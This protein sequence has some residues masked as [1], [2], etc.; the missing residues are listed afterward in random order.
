MRTNQEVR[1]DPPWPALVLLPK[2]ERIS[3]IR[4]SSL[5]PDP[6]RNFPLDSKFRRC[7]KLV[8]ELFVTARRGQQFGI[9]RSRDHEWFFCENF[10]WG[11]ASF[12]M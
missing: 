2:P 3:L 4:P 8:N 7:A 9:D 11:P 12:S 1:Q 6:L 10:V 5:A